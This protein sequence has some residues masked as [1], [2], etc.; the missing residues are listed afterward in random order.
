[1]RDHIRAMRSEAEVFADLSALCRSEG[2]V[3]ALAYLCFRN[4]IVGYAEEL[5]P[6]DMAR[7]LSPEALIRT[8]ISTLIGL[9]IQA[10]VNWAKPSADVIQQQIDRTEALLE[11]LHE[12]FRPAMTA[13]LIEAMKSP[14]PEFNPFKRGELLREAIFYCGES[15]YNFQY[16]DIAPRKYAADDAWLQTNKAFS[17]HTARDVAH[18][19]ERIQGE[20]IAS[21]LE[22]MARLPPPEWSFLSGFT[23]GLSEVAA[24]SGLEVSTVESVLNA[25]TVPAGEKNER[26]C[27]LSD[28]NVANATPIL[29][30]NEDFVSF[31]SYS[32]AAALYE[33][34][35]YWMAADKKYAPTAMQNR[36]SFTEAFCRERLELVFGKD[37]VHSNVDIF[38]SK[39]KKVGEIDVL[40]LFG[41]R[42][43]IVQAKSKRLTLE[44]R[45]GN[46]G[47]LRD[48]FKKSVQDASD[49]GLTCAHRLTDPNVTLV[50][51]DGRE[52]RASHNV[53]EI[54]IL[55]VVSDHYPSLNFQARQ[56]LAFETTK[57][58]QPPL[59]LDIFGLDAMSEMLSTPLRFLSYLNRR[60]YYADKF[61]ASH[62]LIVLSYHLK[63]N[64]WLEDDVGMMYLA[65]DLSADL[66]VAMAV[67]RNGVRGQR[68]PNGM[69][70]RLISTS[71]GR[72]VA[73]IESR[74][75]PGVIDFGFLLLALSEKAVKDVSR[76]IQKIGQLAL[77]DQ[78]AHD[79]TLTLDSA[80]SGI[81]IHSTDGPISVVKPDLQ[82]HCERR[83]YIHKA[84]TWFGVCVH[85]SDESL[86]FGLKLEYE[87]EPNTRLEEMT[88]YMS[89][90]SDPAQSIE[91]VGRTRKVGRNDPCPCGNG[92]KYK[93]C[94]GR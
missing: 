52:I 4:N 54:Y 53:R 1:M 35:F 71:L 2:Y 80:S 85:P 34:P 30:F 47:Q 21:T 26:F 62:E 59:V 43:I 46:D 66:D 90:A 55:C 88:R 83:K 79:L 70:T 38:Q 31:Q 63:H 9:M 78:K 49:Q 75:D 82:N 64:L 39:A 86:R 72:I 56:F 12:T 27:A 61:L 6:E 20:K 58:I 44:A 65:D 19:V 48:D 91:S 22:Q 25:F 15:A 28:F 10:E 23:F 50:G 36:G 84:K 94:H 42:A 69:L 17:I 13:T 14:D 3:H 5:R 11:E 93:K 81:T 60:G 8:E 45:K 29:K 77:S 73:E 74:P 32:L 7:L 24:A 57:V 87:W 92:L 16:R 68:T 67:R 18:A 76:G 33:S 40:V 89:R 51:P 37:R 41:D